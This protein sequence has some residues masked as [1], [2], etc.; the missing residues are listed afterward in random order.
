MLEEIGVIL[1]QN[2]LFPIQS[3][4]ELKLGVT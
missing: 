4:V 2:N 3:P 1:I